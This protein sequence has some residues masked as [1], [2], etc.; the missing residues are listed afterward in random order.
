MEK[1]HKKR[2]VRV[3][4]LAAGGGHDLRQIRQ[5]FPEGKVEYHHV[6]KDPKR[7]KECRV[8]DSGVNMVSHVS[9]SDSIINDSKKLLTLS[10]TRCTST[11][12]RADRDY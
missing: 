12:R 6:D 8:P 9:D 1:S 4:S 7:A 5:F 10:L 11:C 3:L 2:P